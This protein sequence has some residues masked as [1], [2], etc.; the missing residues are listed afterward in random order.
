[1]INIVFYIIC[2]IVGVFIGW[3]VA[4]VTITKAYIG[5]LRM[6]FVNGNLEKTS[7]EFE[8]KKAMLKTENSKYVLVD[9]KRIDLTDN[10]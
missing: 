8:N 9:T 4:I 5:T 6:V 10:A 2:L 7:L 1:M 3:G